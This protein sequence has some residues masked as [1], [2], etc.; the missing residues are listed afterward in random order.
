[1][2]L[3]W[4]SPLPPAQTDIASY[5]ARL[6]P[7][8]AA[9]AEVTLWTDASEWDAELEKYAEV[10]RY[11]PECLAWAD[12][13]RGDM[14]IYH[15]GNNALF[16]GAIWQTSRRHPGVVVLHDTSLQH[17]FAGLFLQ[18]LNDSALYFSAM[19]RYHG[20]T[21][22]VEAEQVF[23]GLANDLDY[24]GKHYPLTSLGIADALGVVV[25][26]EGGL[27]L[28]KRGGNGPP[29]AYIPL[30]FGDEHGRARRSESGGA[31]E[32]GDARYRLIV[33]GHIGSNRGLE[34]VFDALASLPARNRFRLDV[35]GRIW[36]EN[37]LRAKIYACGI[38]QLVTLH[39]FVPDED[40][41][42]ALAAA[43]LAINLRFPSMGEASGS[44]LR[45]W[46]WA[47]PSLVTAL[48]W[49]ATLPA[50]AVAFVR[51][52]HDVEDLQKH[53]N[54]FLSDPASFA[55]M[56]ERG[57]QT[58][59][60]HHAPGKYVDDLLEVVAAAQRFRPRAALYQLAERAGECMSA[61]SD[62]VPGAEACARAAE[63]IDSLGFRSRLTAKGSASR[64]K[65]LS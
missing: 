16:H 23:N 58:L 1:M 32:T 35:Y 52:D 8:L 59:E 42:A 62:S 63:F 61:W 50:D 31:S 36:N 49:Y 53:L 27:S 11:D 13:N 46:S 22:R 10:R 18:Q 64:G 3:N 34:S 38:D 39:G 17:L 56:G 19:E 41:N 30:P 9:R 60:K 6:L 54:A 4:F 5:T 37:Y 28:L 33:F 12:L 48:D 65:P 57:R 43:H 15:V 2:K 14:C 26:T 20:V 29:A 7:A 45:L 21:G 47:L 55:Q 24:L 40:L 51:P 25:H 44:Q